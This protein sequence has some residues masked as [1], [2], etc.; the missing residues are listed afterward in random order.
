M[1]PARAKPK[2][3]SPPDARRAREILDRWAT[4]DRLLKDTDA[5]GDAVGLCTPS[6]LPA[7]A[8]PVF[9]A[10]DLLCDALAAYRKDK[11]EGRA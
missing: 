9:Y 7:A 1:S 8:H 2:P 10:L 5:L 6:E 4:S 11:R 3:G